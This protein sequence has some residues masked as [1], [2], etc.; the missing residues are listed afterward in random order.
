MDN[1]F[2]CFP[3]LGH[4]KKKNKK[5]WEKEEKRKEPPYTFIN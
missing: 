5:A 4:V 3:I 1:E 2:W